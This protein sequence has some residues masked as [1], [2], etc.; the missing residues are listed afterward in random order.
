MAEGIFKW[1]RKFYN[2]F[3]HRIGFMP[4]VMGIGFLS[5]AVGAME[6]DSTGIGLKLNKQFK[7]LMLTDA[8]TA[9]TIVGT[10]AAG[11]I[12]LTVFSF[13]MVMIVMN[14][15]ASQMS[16]RML[17]NIIGDKVQKFILGFYIGTIVFSL[18]LLTNI[19]E[20]GNG[21]NVPSLSVYFLLLLTMFD[22]F[23]FIYFLLPFR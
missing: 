12:S 14:Q 1:I 7:W 17:D 21:V 20:T 4:A 11:I 2:K 9:R 6:L 18:F 16:N 5:L 19:S 10:V 23:L 8:D 3:L 15:A 13:S 22:I